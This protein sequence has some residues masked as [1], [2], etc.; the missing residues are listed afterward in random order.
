MTMPPSMMPDNSAMLR[1]APYMPY[2]ANPSVVQQ[3][4]Q[5][6]ANFQAATKQSKAIK[7]VNPETMTE[8]DISN[9]KTTPPLSS[10]HLTPKSTTETGLQTVDTIAGSKDNKVCYKNRQVMAT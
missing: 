9:L 10:S 7:I 6:P 8:V 1:I 2:M 4:I 3:P 5:Q